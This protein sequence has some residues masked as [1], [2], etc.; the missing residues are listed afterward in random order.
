[1]LLLL[2]GVRVVDV[3]GK[4]FVLVDQIFKDDGLAGD[5]LPDLPLHVNFG[6]QLP[7]LFAQT[8]NSYLP[9]L[10]VP[11]LHCH[12]H[13]YLLVLLFGNTAQNSV[14]LVAEKLASSFLFILFIL[15]L[16]DIFNVLFGSGVREREVV[17]QLVFVFRP[18]DVILF[19]GV[20]FGITAVEGLLGD[21]LLELFIGLRL[22]QVE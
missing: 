14:F 7:N 15:F 2:G 12:A 3:A 21:L 10:E 20:S 13:Q 22:L 1:M 4:L 17:S 8:L 5:V 19:V 6:L 16:D 9:L 11:L 18:F